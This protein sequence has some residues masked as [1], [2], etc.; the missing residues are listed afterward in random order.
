[1]MLD[2]STFFRAAETIEWYSNLVALIEEEIS[3][4][5]RGF[6]KY[7]IQNEVVGIHESDSQ[8]SCRFVFAVVSPLMSPPPSL[9]IVIVKMIWNKRS[10]YIS[11]VSYMIC[12]VGLLTF[13]NENYPQEVGQL[14]FNSIL[15]NSKCSLI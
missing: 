14:I 15:L 13:L 6:D 5:V 11:L 2:I 10:H 7:G 3:H 9:E 12:S 4:G 1:M 8:L